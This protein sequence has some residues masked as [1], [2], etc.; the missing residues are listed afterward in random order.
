MANET[1][2]TSGPWHI[3]KNR[4]WVDYAHEK[5]VV[6]FTFRAD[7]DENEERLDADIRL[8]AAAPELLALAEHVRDGIGV[9]LNEDGSWRPPTAALLR[10]LFDEARAAIAKAEGK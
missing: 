9:F 6:Q 4:T 2:H 10:L 3:R 5:G 8:V 1:K 7:C